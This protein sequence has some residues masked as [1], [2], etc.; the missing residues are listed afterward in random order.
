LKVVH[1]LHQLENLQ[2]V[3]QTVGQ[4]YNGNLHYRNNT[5]A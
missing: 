2:D 4:L 5:G 3:H 1:S